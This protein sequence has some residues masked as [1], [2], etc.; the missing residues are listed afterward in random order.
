MELKYIEAWNLQSEAHRSQDFSKQRLAFEKMKDCANQGNPFA[1]HEL[2]RDYETGEGCS[3]NF[4]EAYKWMLASATNPNWGK[5]TNEQRQFWDH[6]QGDSYFY[7]GYYCSA[8]IGTDEDMKKAMDYWKKGSEYRG[9]R[10]KNCFLQL[11]F[12]YL[13]G[14][15]GYPQS[16]KKA[17]EMFKKASDLGDPDAPYYLSEFYQKGIGGVLQSDS[18][19]FKYIRLSA[20]RGYPDG[21]SLLAEIYYNG[22]LGQPKNHSLAV[23]WWKKAAKQGQ[24]NAIGCLTELGVSW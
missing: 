1:Q 10:Q 22:F 17:F 18:E 16:S 11:A 5:L 7:L 4:T 15:G 3:P 14:L 20:E 23:E 24:S 13:G 21:Q 9:R 12:G 6:S 2:A 19:A 8:G